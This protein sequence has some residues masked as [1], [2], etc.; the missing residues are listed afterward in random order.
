MMKRLFHTATI[1]VTAVALA[2]LSGCEPQ[3]QAPGE[4]LNEAIDEVQEAGEE[5]SREAKEAVDEIGAEMKPEKDKTIGEK[6]EE[7]LEDAGDAIK[8]AIGGNKADPEAGAIDVEVGGG[9]GV[10]VDV[11]PKTEPK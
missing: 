9:K 8:D 11:Q 2:C 7:S 6:V 5:F 4:K 10:R 1:A 3:P